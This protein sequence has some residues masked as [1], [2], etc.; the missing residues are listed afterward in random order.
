MQIPERSGGWGTQFAHP[1]IRIGINPCSYDHC[2]LTLRL[3]TDYKEPVLCRYYGM[4]VHDIYG[5]FGYKNDD[6]LALLKKVTTAYSEASN[7]TGSNCELVVLRAALEKLKAKHYIYDT[8]LDS[9]V[10][11]D[12]VKPNDYDLYMDD[13]YAVDGDGYC[14]YHALAR[15]ASEA[16][17]MMMLECTQKRE[18]WL[19]EKRSYD[20]SENHEAYFTKW[21]TAG[22]P[23]Q[24]RRKPKPDRTTWDDMFYAGGRPSEQPAEALM[25]T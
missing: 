21:V 25:L 1:H 13:R 3:Q 11:A 16:R 5:L 17:A 10:S 2:H 4:K 18:N 22:C 19:L 12:E 24:E 15:S 8:R 9:H 14:K 23:V 6:S 20:W 7:T